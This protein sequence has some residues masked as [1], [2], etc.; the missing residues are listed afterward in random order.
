MNKRTRTKLIKLDLLFL[1]VIW[2]NTKAALH[3]SRFKKG[4]F[5]LAPQAINS[6]TLQF[7]HGGETNISKRSGLAIGFGYNLN[8]NIE[9][10]GR[11]SSTSYSMTDTIIQYDGANTAMPYTSN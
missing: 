8:S 7:E 3:D 4:E 11:L 1:V 6:K 9:L 10:G 2:T 5:F